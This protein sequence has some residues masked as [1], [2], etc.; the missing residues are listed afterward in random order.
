[1]KNSTRMPLGPL[2]PAGTERQS[3][4]ARRFH[5][6]AKPCG[7][8]C[9]LDCTYC[10]YLHKET[11]LPHPPGRMREATL[12]RFIRQYIEANDAESVVFS[13]QGGEPTLLGI[14]FFETALRLQKKYARPGAAVA[15]TLQTNG[16]LL[17]DE[18]G[19]FL[20][21]HGFLV[22]LSVDGPEEL[23]NLHRRDKA[24]APTF[25]RVMEGH[26]HLRRHGVPFTVLTTVNRH[27]AKQPLEVYR[28]LT[29]ELGADYVQFNPCVEAAG[30]ADTAPHFWE[31]ASLPR[32][33]TPRSRPGKESIVTEW[34]VDADDWGD[35]L[36]AVFDE[37]LERDL[38]RVLVNWFETA[39][40]QT[41]QLPA[42]ICMT[43][44]ICGKGV[45]LEHTGHVYACDH[46]V[47]PEY[48][49]GHIE[50]RSLSDLV[51]SERQ[52]AFGFGKRNTLPGQ[53]LR[54]PHG[55]LCWGQCPRHRLLKTA[56]GEAGLNYLCPGLRK[57]YSHSKAAVRAIAARCLG[58]PEE[59]AP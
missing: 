52:R 25:R 54:C 19:G 1:M 15:N 29:R 8:A 6:M 9:N 55:L 24:G 37:W 57:F 43:G 27:N 14:D 46:Y 5:V 3:P 7:A 26:G 18:W 34:S 12:E 53:C 44:E 10:Y 2:F 48:C 40:A 33:G 35:F 49:L 16:T 59:K 36:C 13:W 31:Q 45:A 42:Q 41:M 11:L 23:H 32:V 4:R 58:L 56:D 47:Y 51:F 20:K 22:G 38:G 17:T 30:F 21:E 28:F 39:V 50:E